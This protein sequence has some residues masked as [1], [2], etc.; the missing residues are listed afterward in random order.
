MKTCLAALLSVSLLAAAPQLPPGLAAQRA[1]WEGVDEMDGFRSITLDERFGDRVSQRVPLDPAVIGHHQLRCL[2]VLH[3]DFQGRDRAGELIVHASLADE[4]LDIF[5]DLYQLG[6]PIEK[7]RLVDEY[8]FSDERSMADNNS[9][10]FNFRQILG[11]TE[12]SNH[13]FG[14]AI[15]LNPVVNP[16]DAA[17]YVL[18]VGGLLY[19]DRDQPHKGIIRHGDD[20][21]QIFISRGWEWGGDW[22]HVKDYHHFEKPAAL[23]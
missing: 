21:Y 22:T 12:L 4:V 23:G 20:V 13:A 1:H 9:S 2:K 18:P 11:G 17:E 16:Y 14:I 15:D 10:G 6:Y 7:L 3:K 8:D 19:L 5:R